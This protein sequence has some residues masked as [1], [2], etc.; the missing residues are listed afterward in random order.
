VN[1]EPALRRWSLAAALAATVAAASW[2][3]GE[4]ND[5]SAAKRAGGETR[6]EPAAPTVPLAGPAIPATDLGGTFALKLHQRTMARE[7][8]DVFES[9]SW[10]PQ[11]VERAPGP[12]QAPAVPFA[13]AGRMIERG[14][15]TVFLEAGDRI[16]AAKA[17]QTVDG[18]YR[19]DGIH[20]DTVSLTYL[21][22]GTRQTLQLRALTDTAHPA[23]A[24]GA[25]ASTMGRRTR[26][27]Q[28][29]VA[30]VAAQPDPGPDPDRPAQRTE[31]RPEKPP[32]YAAPGG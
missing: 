23:A 12:P 32:G 28:V 24:A 6:H 20:G 26:R 14:E 8:V 29:D 27:A 15:V 17:A 22:L 4:Q 11:P 10:E 19:I 31:S 9:R 21:P 5:G 30:P 7:S 2:V 25:P 18:R 16:H 3:G 1:W 13:Y